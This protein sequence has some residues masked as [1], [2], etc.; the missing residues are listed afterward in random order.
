MKW[1]KI[2]KLHLLTL[3][4]LGFG[5]FVGNI[6]AHSHYLGE[7]KTDSD[8]FITQIEFKDKE[9]NLTLNAKKIDENMKK[10]MYFYSYNTTAIDRLI[11][12]SASTE[13]M[14]ETIEKYNLNFSKLI[15]NSSKFE[16]VMAGQKA[17]DMLRSEMHGV[18]LSV[19]Q[20]GSIQVSI[21]NPIISE[22]DG[23]QIIKAFNKP[24]IQLENLQENQFTLDGIEYHQ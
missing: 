5:Y 10:F 24:V 6:Q 9:V 3:F 19:Q 2:C 14:K 22:I 8:A 18:F 16:K 23:R 1:F 11:N 4:I 20:D 21:V 17:L 15:E 13:E 12:P 7:F